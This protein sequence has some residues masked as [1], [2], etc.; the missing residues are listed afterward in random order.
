MRL[1]SVYMMAIGAVTFFPVPTQAMLFEEVDSHFPTG[2]AYTNNKGSALETTEPRKQ[3][4]IENDLE[5]SNPNCQI[6]INKITEVKK[7]LLD[8]EDQSHNVPLSEKNRY[9]NYFED[10]NGLHGRAKKDQ[11]MNVRQELYSITNKY[12]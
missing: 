11:S 7:I 8:Y 2:H 4:V 9:K 6:I 1:R 12:F 3:K 5:E 10:L